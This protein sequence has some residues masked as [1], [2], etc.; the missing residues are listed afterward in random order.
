MRVLRNFN[1][2]KINDVVKK[3]W[4]YKFATLPKHEDYFESN[5]TLSKAGLVEALS[6]YD[7]APPATF[8]LLR[9]NHVD[10]MLSHLLLQAWAHKTN[11]WQWFLDF[12][13]P[14]NIVD[15]KPFI[16]L[17]EILGVLAWY[18][19]EMEIR[20]E[21][22]RIA[23]S[24]KFK[25]IDCTIEELSTVEG[26]KEF[27]NNFNFTGTP[28]LPPKANT[29]GVQI[30]QDLKEQVKAFVTQI[31]FINPKEMAKEYMKQNKRWVDG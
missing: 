13:Y 26:A 14:L 27:L 18:I 15:P 16:E 28:V 3:F 5:H 6:K 30:P 22:Y 11:V 24:S 17:N 19:V 2:H 9:R 4:E 29:L 21:C 8:V 31:N 12:N 10:L 20:Q 1:T 7:D 25:F 23:F